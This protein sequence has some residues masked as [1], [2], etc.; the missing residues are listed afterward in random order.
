MDEDTGLASSY[1]DTGNDREDMANFYRDLYGVVNPYGGLPGSS[2]EENDTPISPYGYEENNSRRG[3]KR[4]TKQGST[5]DNFLSSVLSALGGGGGASSFADG[6]SSSAG[7][8]ESSGGGLLSTLSDI[9]KGMRD[10][11]LINTVVDNSA[12]HAS[13]LRDIANDPPRPD[14]VNAPNLRGPGP[15]TGHT[16]SPPWVSGKQSAG[17]V[18]PWK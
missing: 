8:E 9:F 10:K 4:K 17:P 7:G 15:L 18:L 11:K 2:Q 16:T 12:R 3:S 6:D 5:M 14:W 13:W 1:P